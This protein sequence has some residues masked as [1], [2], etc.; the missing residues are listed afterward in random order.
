[1]QQTTKKTKVRYL[2]EANLLLNIIYPTLLFEFIL[3]FL[4]IYLK[5]II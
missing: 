3:F 1:M 2:I 5:F 4:H